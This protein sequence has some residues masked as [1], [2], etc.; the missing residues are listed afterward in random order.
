MLNAYSCIISVAGMSAGLPKY[1]VVNLK[2][3]SEKFSEGEEVSLDTMSEKRM[4]NLSGREAKL[5]LK[6][7]HTQLCS[8]AFLH[9]TLQRLCLLLRTSRPMRVPKQSSKWHQMLFFLRTGRTPKLSC[10]VSGWL[11]ALPTSFFWCLCVLKSSD[12][13]CHVLDCFDAWTVCKPFA[14]APTRVFL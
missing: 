2:T 7:S 5:P 13:C 1:I 6:V 12:V 8:R 10:Q 9:K 14:I 3:L 4:L 11:P